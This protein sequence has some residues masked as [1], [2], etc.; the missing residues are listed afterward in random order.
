MKLDLG[1]ALECTTSSPYAS[2]LATWYARTPRVRRLWAIDD[3]NPP[4]SSMLERLRVIVMLEPSGDSDE[5][6]AAWMARGRTWQQELRSQLACQVNLEWAD[7][8]DLDEIEIDGDGVVVVAL[9]WR[10]ATSS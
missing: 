5:T 3:S 2:S 4:G 7:G 1:E 6:S 9:C 8:G 10:D